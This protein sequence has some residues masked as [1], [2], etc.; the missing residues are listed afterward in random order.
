MLPPP[1]EPHGS[2][3]LLATIVLAMCA[4]LL[5]ATAP[6]YAL[7]IKSAKVTHDP[8]KG[9]SFTVKGEFGA[10][11]FDGAAAVTLEFDGFLSGFSMK[12]LKR[13]K[14]QLSV[15]GPTGAPGLAQ[16][17]IDLAKHRFRARVNHVLLPSIPD[18]IVVRLGTD[19]ASDCALLPLAATGSGK[20]KPGAK[21]KPVHFA[22]PRGRQ[23]AACLVGG[24]VMAVPP[25]VVVAV[26]TSVRFRVTPLAGLTL[27]A[28]S[29]RLFVAD[30]VGLPLG[31]PLCT[32]ADDGSAGAGDLVAADGTDSCRV[33][34]D[35]PATGPLPLVVQGTAAGTPLRSPTLFLPIVP[36]TTDADIATMF[37]DQA[38]IR[39]IWDT[40]VAAHGDSLNARLETIREAASLPGVASAGLSPDG[41]DIIVLYASG[42][43][44]GLMLSPRF[45][46]VTAPTATATPAPPGAASLSFAPP[47]TVKRLP[48]FAA[49]ARASV[50]TV[51]CPPNPPR[52]VV[53]PLTALLLTSDYFGLND[54]APL[55]RSALE[56][57]CL[58]FDVHEQD[59]T[60]DTLQTITQ[61]STVII[62]THGILSETYGP[63]MVT[64]ETAIVDQ[65]TSTH[66]YS[67]FFEPFEVVAIGIPTKDDKGHTILGGGRDVYAVTPAFLANEIPVGAMKHGFVYTSHC[68]SADTPDEAQALL[69]RGASAVLGFTNAVSYN[70]SRII[71][72]TVLPTLTQAL[73]ATGEAYDG[74]IKIDPTP[75]SDTPVKGVVFH[76]G[77]KLAPPSGKQPAELVLAGDRTLAYVD[78][79]MV[80]P[81][82]AT[83][84]A[85]SETGFSVSVPGAETCSLV[86]HWSTEADVGTLADDMSHAGAQIDTTE[87][88]VDFIANADA[89]GEVSV[90]VGARVP[91]TDVGPVPFFGE[92]CAVVDVLGCG[93]GVVQGSEQC[94]GGDDAACPGQCTSDCTCPHVPMCGDDHRDPGE[95]CDGT[96]KVV[97]DNVT[98]GGNGICSPDCESC[99]RCGN[100]LI[101]QAS[102]ECDGPDD[103][104]CPNAC[105][106]DCTCGCTFGD[107]AGCPATACCNSATH[108][109]CSP[110]PYPSGAPSCP[111]TMNGCC[112]GVALFPGFCGG[113][114]AK[115]QTDP[116]TCP[117]A[118]CADVTGYVC[119]WCDNKLIQAECDG[120]SQSCAPE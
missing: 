76:P 40:K 57:S 32:L 23:A 84:E 29:L 58:K 42:H 8:V 75:V 74:A 20:K 15:K 17:A 80:T 81:G 31:A 26:P 72:S 4:V 90:I 108:E 107:P 56:H 30:A 13:R 54:D 101:D 60:I 34:I 35:Q 9:D 43:L 100:N 11:P 93:D 88:S 19:T 70:Y 62:S 68:H 106:A 85:G 49:G 83:I 116:A 65:V 36:P 87:P 39:A 71:A 92:A 33:T 82:S 10:L 22:V 117:D 96:D 63:M 37:A 102:E 46:D 105:R 86:Y 3:R 16:L 55:A 51:T 41:L 59:L 50:D 69:N 104:A 28:G 21:P 78:R 119:L 24:P 5:A 99:L 1:I 94:D 95:L 18:P 44:G 112:G 110:F 52:T 118:S 25:A 73:L 115:G 2:A 89:F 14:Q 7:V 79:P 67:G 6:G 103:D 109:C 45:G 111:F 113:D 77:V 97:C 120:N 27:D 114:L 91:A 66:A 98:P 47:A 12:D 38:Q 53:G 64:N 61:Y 48:S